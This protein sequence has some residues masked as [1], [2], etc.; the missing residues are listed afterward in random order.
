MNFEW[1]LNDELIYSKNE[2]LKAFRDI[3]KV[4]IVDCIFISESTMWH[5]KFFFETI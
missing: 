4:Q 5:A 2:I 3:E 1:A